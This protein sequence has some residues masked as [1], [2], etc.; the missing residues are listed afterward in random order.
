LVTLGDHIR[1]ARLLRGIMQVE[2]AREMGVSYATFHNW[3]TGERAPQK[4]L[5]ERI[6]GFLGY[7]PREHGVAF[8]ERVTPKMRKQSV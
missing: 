1:K 2:A 5:R 6:R 8:P 7:D 3:E 4:H